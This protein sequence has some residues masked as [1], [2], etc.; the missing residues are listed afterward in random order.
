M[1]K[2]NHNNDELIKYDI[3]M[4]KECLQN[5]KSYFSKNND[6]LNILN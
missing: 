4:I 2:K 1:L 5:L 3:K 6:K